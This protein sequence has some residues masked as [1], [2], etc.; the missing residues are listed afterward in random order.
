MAVGAL[1]AAVGLP[2][3]TI[4]VHLEDLGMMGFVRT[5]S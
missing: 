1:S 4:R 3:T 5:G 2:L